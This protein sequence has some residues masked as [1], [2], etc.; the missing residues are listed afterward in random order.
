MLLVP[1]LLSLTHRVKQCLWNAY[2]HF[3]TV[4]SLLKLGA[5]INI[6]TRYYRERF[7]HEFVIYLLAKTGGPQ[8]NSSN[9]KTANNLLVFVFVFVDLRFEDLKF[10]IRK[11]ILFLLI[12]IAYDSLIQICTLVFDT[13]FCNFL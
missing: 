3:C 6:G 8:I 12:N 9:R 1:L 10:K 2:I 13:K 11:N 4:C 5:W 7:F